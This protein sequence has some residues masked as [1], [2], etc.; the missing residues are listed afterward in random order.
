MFEKGR[1]KWLK[2][3]LP[4]LLEQMLSQPFDERSDPG[5]PQVLQGSARNP[6][7]NPQFLQG[8]ACNPQ[9]NPQPYTKSLSCISGKQKGYGN[10]KVKCGG[11]YEGTKRISAGRGL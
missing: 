2:K 4:S 7:C 1:V 8:S 9:C 3:H 5:K 6:Q 10:T 11:S